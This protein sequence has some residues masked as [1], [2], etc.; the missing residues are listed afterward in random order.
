MAIGTMNQA[1]QKYT[2][3]N[4]VET[5]LKTKTMREGL[6]E[7][8]NTIKIRTDYGNINLFIEH[9]SIRVLYRNGFYFKGVSRIL[10]KSELFVTSVHKQTRRAFSIARLH[11]TI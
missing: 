2:G 11:Q 8:P 1:N 7:S 4:Q 3:K 6:T 10:G 9:F 5:S